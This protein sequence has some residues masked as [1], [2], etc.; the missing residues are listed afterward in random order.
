MRCTGFLLLSVFFQDH[1]TE[2]C[3]NCWQ[4][5]GISHLCVPVSSQLDRR[6]LS[7][8]ANGNMQVPHCRTST[9]AYRTLTCVESSSWNSFPLHLLTVRL[10]LK[11]VN[12]R[13]R[14]RPRQWGPRPR[15]RRDTRSET[16]RDSSKR[17]KCTL[18]PSPKTI[19]PNF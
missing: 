9:R 10:V 4:C 16:V 8:S 1:H 12:S 15:P 6:S 18:D 17:V 2:S 11:T 13:P 7:P 5:V 3:L 14:P 19:F